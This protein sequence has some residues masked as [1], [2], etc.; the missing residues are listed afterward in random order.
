MAS[1]KKTP[2]GTFQIRVT[3]KL[4]PK[5]L[6]ATF[7]TEEQAR[8]YADQL[9][10]LLGQGIVPAALLERSTPSREI[11]TVSRC[12]AEYIRANPVPLSDVKLL[13]TIRSQLS[14]LSTG[15]L[16]YDWAD[17]WVRSMKR[18]DNLAPSTIQ[19]RHGALARCFDWMMRKHPDIIAQNPLRLLKRGFA[20]YTPE[21]EKILARSGKSAKVGEERNRRMDAEEEKRIRAI[22][23]GRPEEDLVFFVLAL[24][25]AMRM[26]EC[27]TL[28]VGQVDLMQRTIN[29][30]RTKNGDRRQVPLSSTAVATLREHITKQGAAIQKRKGRLFSYWNGDASVG[31]LDDATSDVSRRFRFIFEK[32]NAFELHFHDLRHEATCRLYEKTTLSDVLIARI[33]GHRDLRMLKRYASLRGSELA[34]HLW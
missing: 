21:D 3:N 12:I 29:L 32:A 19:H 30:E 1:I 22:L 2:S 25:T 33:T 15:C 14:T 5:P 4:L 31:G 20:V 24:E 8:A 16:N 10:A 18:D 34:Q 17:N 11:W 26:R 6:W 27:Y 23:A 28:E 9:E 13:D 7:D